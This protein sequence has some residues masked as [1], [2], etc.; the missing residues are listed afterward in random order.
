MKNLTRILALVLVFTMM[1]S[2]AAFAAKFSDVAD[3]ST[4]AE[5]TQ[6]LS[7]LG[8]FNGYEDGTFK[9][10]AVITR[11]EV[12]AVCNRLQGLSD[13]AKAAAGTTV[14][15][16]VPSN[17]WY[18]GDVN[19]AS[20]MGVVSGDGNGLF[21]PNDQVKYE[22]AVKMM[23]AALG[24]N[25]DY[26][27]KQGGW[28]TGY[29]V[30]ATDKGVTKG[31]SVAAGEP[32]YR[33]VVAKLAYQSL[34]AP[35]MVLSTYDDD[36]KATYR[37][38]ATKTLLGTKLGYAKLVGHV[39]ANEVSSVS[40]SSALDKGYITYSFDAT[41]LVTSST[42]TQNGY[43]NYVGDTDV[44]SF[45]G[46]DEAITESIAVGGT[47]VASTLGYATEI[48]VDDVDGDPVV[49]TYI[50]STKSN[51]EAEV[52]KAKYVQT[53]QTTPKLKYPSDL[54]VS[55][56]RVSGT[57]SVYDD[58]NDSTNTEYTLDK[59]AVIYNGEY[60]A[61]TASSLFDDIKGNYKSLKLL[62]NDGDGK[63]ELVFV[64]AYETAVVDS[65]FS[66]NKK[67][68]MK[69]GKTLDLTNFVDEKDGYTYS[70]KLDGKDIKVADLK[71][72]DVLSIA[73]T[74]NGKNINIIVSRTAVEGAVEGIDPSDDTYTIASKEYSIAPDVDSITLDSNS[75]GKFYIT[76]FGDI[77]YFDGDTSLSG[78]V[79]FIEKVGETEDMGDTSY[80]VQFLNADGSVTK[81]YLADKV[82]VNNVSAT[83]DNAA[84]VYADIEALVTA[85]KTN[86]N[87]AKRM[88]TY[89]T[90]GSGKVNSI[91][92][93]KDAN[94]G[95]G[96]FTEVAGEEEYDAKVTSFDS[97]GI[98]E[99]TTVFYVPVSKTNV[100]DYE[101]SN[102]K[103][104]KDGKTYAVSF[105][106]IDDDNN[107]GIVVVT[108]EAKNIA[109][110]TTLAVVTNALKVN[111]AEG[112]SCVK[113][114]FLQDGAEKSLLTD[115]DENF[116]YT[117]FEK[118]M[119]FNYSVNGKDEIDEIDIVAKIANVDA[120]KDA[121][122]NA[123]AQKR[124]ENSDY[125]YVGGYVVA[126]NSSTL[127]LNTDFAAETGTRLAVPSS[128]NIYYIDVT[129][130]KIK[131]TVASIGDIT[132]CKV[133]YDD[134]DT[135]K[136]NPIAEEDC[137]SYI[138]G[139]YVDKTL[140]DVVVY[141]GFDID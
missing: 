68:G 79:A 86:A 38:D 71:E 87:F 7:A 61:T 93:A 100:D 41:Q 109:D 132:A 119:I 50:N 116:D 114:T 139:K 18:A 84:D 126:K 48:Y 85:S 112:N 49:L 63:Y 5:A 104:F 44:V 117:D 74:K 19:L 125:C 9:P 108:N 51:D 1:I 128:A 52:K 24:Y 82:K 40:S 31:L 35:M 22:E 77:A 113:V 27:L 43:K 123:F 32:A 66:Q 21:R 53:N 76:Y 95:D 56:Q 90:N 140:V 120:G 96:L 131:P 37:A 13:A 88:V 136:S 111:N 134:A 30:I 101:V 12:V 26:V 94:S 20:Q 45:K 106:N 4:Y 69:V 97:Y 110:D 39:N 3:G 54:S 70:I 55:E 59:A 60:V 29:L 8:I 10:D 92:F 129:K 98:K 102:S 36:G 28:P 124:T 64:T 67:V 62:D 2:S 15:T 99:S 11:A 83:S 16:D 105:L 25:Q 81:L 137:N 91:N 122:G 138:V 42:S 72:F 78:T 121:D 14:F 33:G 141:Y 135:S 17:E 130:D 23:V 107:A 133:Y 73:K 118:G 34:T 127:T 75:E 46:T 65:V 47:D 103:F 58:D 57:L 115:S 89:K 80:Q 6:V